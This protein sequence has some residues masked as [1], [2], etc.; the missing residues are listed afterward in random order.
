[1]F[2][3]AS[4]LAIYYHYGKHHKLNMSNVFSYTPMMN[5]DFSLWDTAQVTDMSYIFIST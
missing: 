5:E 4:S 3:S 2:W 1:M